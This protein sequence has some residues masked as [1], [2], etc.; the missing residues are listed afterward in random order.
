MV[1]PKWVSSSKL[2]DRMEEE[3]ELEDFLVAARRL[4]IMLKDEEKCDII[5]AITH[6]SNEE[7]ETL[8][9][10]NLNH[11]NIILGGHDHIYYIKKS[12][13]K[14]LLKSGSDFDQ[15]SV[16]NIKTRKNNEPNE[17]TKIDTKPF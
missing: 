6:M 2:K 13:N 1:S 15:F 12:N 7:D 3:F 4:S 16:V 9:D 17:I 10:D 11:I 14:I 8:L 5:F